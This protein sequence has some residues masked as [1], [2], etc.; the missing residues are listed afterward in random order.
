MGDSTTPA[1][2]WTSYRRKQ[3]D[4]VLA[5]LAF[6]VS[7]GVANGRRCPHCGLARYAEA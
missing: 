1:D 6:P 3:R 4:V 5:M 7:A 2:A